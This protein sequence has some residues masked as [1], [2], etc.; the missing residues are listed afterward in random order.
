MKISKKDLRRIIKEEY[1][2]VYGKQQPKRRR[3]AQKQ[4]RK[5]KALNEFAKRAY[6]LLR[7]AGMSKEV[8]KRNALRLRAQKARK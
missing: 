2:Y 1:E 3:T 8:A 7:E 6:S 4:S 5:V